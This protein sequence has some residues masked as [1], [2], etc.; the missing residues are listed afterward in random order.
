MFFA[1]R[2]WG[3]FSRQVVLGDTLDTERVNA[4]FADGVL[5]VTMPVADAAKS[6][7][8][9]ITHAPLR[10]ESREVTT[11]AGEPAPVSVN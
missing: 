7:R 4:S 5:T 8:I 10:A 1:E 2:P 6:R 3:R 9:E 11:E